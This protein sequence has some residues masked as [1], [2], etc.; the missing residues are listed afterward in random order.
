MQHGIAFSELLTWIADETAR[1]E[2]WTARQDAA[3]WAIPAGSGRIATLHDL[4]FHV[5][6]VDLRYGQRLHGRPVSAYEDEPCADAATL[7]ALARRGQALLHDALALD[8]S[9]VIEFQTLSAGTLRA[10]KRKVLAHSLTHHLRHLAQ[11]A[12][13]VRQHG[14]PTDWPHDLMMS[15]ALA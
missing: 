3:I 1:W 8:L 14:H 12:T 5:F 7:F 9:P 2:A 13:L 10:S 15:G 6:I 11:A 4:L